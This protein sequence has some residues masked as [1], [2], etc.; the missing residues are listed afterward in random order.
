[1]RVVPRHRI[2]H[3]SRRATLAVFA[4]VPVALDATVAVTVKIAVPPEM[5]STVVLMLPLPL[6][7]SQFEPDDATHTNSPK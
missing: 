7:A 6:T 3:A 2:G 4:N 1:L 5:R